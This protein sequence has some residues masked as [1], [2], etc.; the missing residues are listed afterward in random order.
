[1]TCDLR[2]GDDVIHDFRYAEINVLA[3]A[4]SDRRPKNSPQG[5]FLNAFPPHRFESQL[6]RYVFK[7][8][9]GCS[10]VKKVAEE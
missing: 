10:I 3:L 1:M 7:P 4:R 2:G 5:C 9:I 6:L 8:H